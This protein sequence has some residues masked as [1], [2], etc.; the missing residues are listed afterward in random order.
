MR[1]ARWPVAGGGELVIINSV[2][3]GNPVTTSQ[4]N[5]S[6]SDPVIPTTIDAT[7]VTTGSVKPTGPYAVSSWIG[8]TGTTDMHFGTGEGHSRHQVFCVL[9]HTLDA[10]NHGPGVYDF[11]VIVQDVGLAGGFATKSVSADLGAAS[12][13]DAGLHMKWPI[14]G[15][16]DKPSDFAN[17]ALAPFIGK[18]QAIS[19]WS[20]P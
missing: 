10:F 7:F 12:S 19:N 4:C 15:D 17:A 18:F 14:L 8:G 5:Q 16:L 9:E 1:A 20:D 6:K 2:K 3:V 11:S 13:F